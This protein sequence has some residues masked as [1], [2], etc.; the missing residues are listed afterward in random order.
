VVRKPP[1]ASQVLGAKVRAKARE[2]LFLGCGS[3]RANLVGDVGV[4]KEEEEHDSDAEEEGELGA[5]VLIPE[6]LSR[7]E[8]PQSSSSGAFF[9]LVVCVW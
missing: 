2:R 6:Q 5:R 4:G 9:R 7:E 8:E 1:E 3:P